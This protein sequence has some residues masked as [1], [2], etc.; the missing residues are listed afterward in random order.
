MGTVGKNEKATQRS[1]VLIRNKDIQSSSA[2]SSERD[3]GGAYI[4]KR[5][6]HYHIAQ[7]ARKK[8]NFPLTHFRRHFP[9]T[10]KLMNYIFR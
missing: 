10:L 4:E 5:N 9:P 6:H 1:L 3:E 7:K 8:M 2:K